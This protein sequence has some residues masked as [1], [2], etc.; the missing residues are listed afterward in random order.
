M[1]RLKLFGKNYNLLEKFVPELL[2]NEEPNFYLDHKSKSTHF[3]NAYAE[4]QD[5]NQLLIGYYSAIE[6]RPLKGYN[7]FND[8]TLKNKYK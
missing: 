1:P 8:R 5:E 3:E 6:K 2:V 4:W 7:T